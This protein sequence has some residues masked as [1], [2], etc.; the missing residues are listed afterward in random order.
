V[1]DDVESF[2][3][4]ENRFRIARLADI[5][6]LCHA[7]MHAFLSLFHTR[8]MMQNHPLLQNSSMFVGKAR[9]PPL[10]LSLM[11]GSSWV[12]SNLPLKY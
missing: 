10:A 7:H 5:R 3:R 9:S 11:R 8:Q 2:G 4:N 1:E 12:S 6:A